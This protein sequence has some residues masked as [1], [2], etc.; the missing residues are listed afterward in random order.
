MSRQKNETERVRYTFDNFGN[1]VPENAN[2]DPRIKMQQR[3]LA[4]KAVATQVPQPSKPEVFR[5]RWAEYV[6]EKWNYFGRDTRFHFLA[7]AG[8]VFCFSSIYFS[9]VRLDDWTAS[10][11]NKAYIP[12]DILDRS[13]WHEYQRNKYGLKYD[14]FMHFQTS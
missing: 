14:P 5:L 10:M 6:W 13:S 12:A 1:L 3:V 2:Q 9:A 4:Q 7:L 8:I 11:E